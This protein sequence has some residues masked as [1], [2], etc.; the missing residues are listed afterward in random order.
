[1]TYENATDPWPLV[2]TFQTML[3]RIPAVK[4]QLLIELLMAAHVANI[5]GK[6]HFIIDSMAKHAKQLLEPDRHEH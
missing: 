6:E 2:E 5:P 4:Q 1:M 3:H